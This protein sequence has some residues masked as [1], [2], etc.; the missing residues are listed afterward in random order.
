MNGQFN[1]GVLVL[2]ASNQTLQTIQNLPAAGTIAAPNI[3][4][5][6]P[7]PAAISPFPPVPPAL[8]P[9][10]PHPQVVPN[11]GVGF[12][13]QPPP[14]PRVPVRPGGGSPMVDP[15]HRNG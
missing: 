13:P 3:Q 7:S 10:I 5:I 1:Q 15:R 11:R 2:G 4:H 8:G 6:Q 14:P 12:P 9:V